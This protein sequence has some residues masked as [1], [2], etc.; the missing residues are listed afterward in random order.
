ML[1]CQLGELG[2]LVIIL[3]PAAL[4]AAAPARS[5]D[6]RS[7]GGAKAPRR[8]AVPPRRPVLAG[9]AL[10]LAQTLRIARHGRVAPSIPMLLELPEES[11]GV[12]VTRIPAVQEIR[13]IGREDAAAAISAALALRQ[14]CHAKVPKHGILANPQLLGHG[15]PRPPLMV[16]GPDVLMECQ[17]PRLALVR[18]LLGGARRGG[19][20]RCIPG[21]RFDDLLCGPLCCR[22][23]GDMEAHDAAALVSQDAED[24]KYLECDS[25]NGEEVTCHD[26]FD[27]V[28][29][30]SPP[31][32]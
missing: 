6:G 28:V 17:P 24:E 30:E 25:W 20:W 21:K 11:Y 26:V 32:W 3:P 4:V 7:A 22:V 27:M 2:G 19:G 31:V 1:S 16:A 13:F 12:T 23:F 8:P 14:R 18:Q 9:L 10:G 15:P 29:Q 5:P